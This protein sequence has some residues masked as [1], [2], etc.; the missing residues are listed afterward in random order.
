MSGVDKEG[1]I[2][3]LLKGIESEKEIWEPVYL[4]LIGKN[5]NFLKKKDDVNP[6][7][8]IEL[9]KSDLFRVPSSEDRPFIFNIYYNNDI[10][11]FSCDNNDNFESW[12]NVLN[13]PK[14]SVWSTP[15][16]PETRTTIQINYDR[17][18]IWA[19]KEPNQNL[20]NDT[21]DTTIKDDPKRKSSDTDS[22][23]EKDNKKMAMYLLTI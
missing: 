9:E 8:C 19:K 13:I 18:N 5:L 3:I 23:E 20:T 10:N 7:F 12:V 16:H 4:K 14:K 2:L 22:I 17:I 1:Y 21:S 6:Y 11:T 15:K